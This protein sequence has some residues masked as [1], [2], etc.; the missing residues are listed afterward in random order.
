M[1]KPK[2]TLDQ[3]LYLYG[4]AKSQQRTRTRHL[5]SLRRL[6]LTQPLKIERHNIRVNY[7]SGLNQPPV[8]EGVGSIFFYYTVR[9]L[10]L[11]KANAWLFN[12]AV[13]E[14]VLV[15]LYGTNEEEMSSFR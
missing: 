10:V 2:R 4:N 12:H 3:L 13:C 5:T 15:N 7:I 1:C 11:F 14:I 6:S 9:V 8:R